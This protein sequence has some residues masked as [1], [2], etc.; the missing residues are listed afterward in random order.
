[1]EE[2]GENS[3]NE[4]TRIFEELNFSTTVIEK[5]TKIKIWDDRGTYNV[6]DDS[7]YITSIKYAG[8]IMACKFLLTKNTLTTY[9]LI[10][11]EDIKNLIDYYQFMG[12]S[13]NNFNVP[14]GLT[15]ILKT[16]EWRD[17]D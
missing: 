16:K 5:N 17:L 11:S 8:G 3:K 9:M 4:T 13:S 12:I 1:M 2:A 10:T 14:E 7:I 15:G 6:K